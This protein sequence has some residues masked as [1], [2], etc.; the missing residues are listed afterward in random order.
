V[1]PET[2]LL[3]YFVAVAEELNFTRAAG[4]LHV[5]QQALSAQIRLLERELGAE[6]LR[7]TTHRVEL[8]PAGAIFLE[9]ARQVLALA[10]RA[11]E[12]A[13]RAG[14][15]ELGALGIAYTETVSYAA[16]PALLDA[17][18]AAYPD[19]EVA[20]RELTPPDLMAAVAE[21]RLD[22]AVA[23]EPVPHPGL[24]TETLLREP[25]VAALSI[26]HP[27]A[28]APAIPLSALAG[29]T[30]VIWPRDLIPGYYDT[31]I[32]AFADVGL[33]PTVYT[34][35]IG[36]ALWHEIAAG[37]GVTLAVASFAA[38]APPGVALVPLIEPA[39]SLS[40][41][42]VWREGALSPQGQRFLAIARRVAEEAGWSSRDAGGE[43]AHEA[44]DGTPASL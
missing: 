27:L 24:A 44:A 11:A 37:R 43:P 32:R 20:A 15:G 13:A 23:R 19:V 8:T 42:L 1:V 41:S 30:L 3:R 25:L 22:L 35:V 6:L 9:D 36:A 2:R 10:E 5:A 17:F 14:R 12:R 16:L 18:R 34:A 33:T 21:G 39:P 7:R 26:R 29:E 38:H 31:L 4:R 28:G 40:V